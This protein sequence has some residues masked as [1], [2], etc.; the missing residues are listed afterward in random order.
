MNGSVRSVQASPCMCEEK[1]ETEMMS[2]QVC[3]PVQRVRVLRA[4]D[5]EMHCH[6]RARWYIRFEKAKKKKVRKI[7]YGCNIVIL[8]NRLW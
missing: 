1:R 2:E 8:I 4:A 7:T 5:G 3:A 6:A